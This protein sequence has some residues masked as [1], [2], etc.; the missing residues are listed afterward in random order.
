M[1]TAAVQ[2]RVL[3][4]LQQAFPDGST[5]WSLRKMAEA[6]ELSKST[7]QSIWAGARLPPH[8][9]ERYM[10]SPDP[11]FKTKAVDILE[12]YLNPPQHAAVFYVDEKTAIQALDRKD[13]RLPLSP[14]RAERH[15]FEYY[16]HGT[17]SFY[18]TK[19]VSS[20]TWMVVECVICY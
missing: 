19:T 12:I 8:C 14:G 5:H 9:L 13:T 1:A 18:Q 3:K 10:A 17:L 2:A 20:P 11:D 7:A 4:K 16:R 15:R 6:L